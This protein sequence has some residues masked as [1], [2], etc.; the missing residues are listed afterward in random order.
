MDPIQIKSGAA[1]RLI[2]LLPYSSERVAKIKTV[3]GL[4]VRCTQT[5]RR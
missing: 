1:G 3:V 5:G 4:P 2:V